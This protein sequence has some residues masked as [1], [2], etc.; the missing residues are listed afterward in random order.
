MKIWS[1]DSDWEYVLPPSRP[2]KFQLDIVEDRIKLLPCDAKV[3][4]LGSTPE[5]RD[6]AYQMEISNIY[7][8]DKSVDFYQKSSKM[9]VYNN[10]EILIKG[11]WLETLGN[12]KGCFDLIL[13][14]LTAGNIEYG[15]RS[16]F[17]QLIGLALKKD[18]IFIDKYLT[19]E[20]GVLTLDEI[21][22]KYSTIPINLATVNDFSC[23]AIFCSELQKAFGIIDTTMIYKQLSQRFCKNERLLK[24]IELA[25]YITPEECIWYYGKEIDYIDDLTLEVRKTLVG[26][27]Y[28]NRA[29]IYIWKK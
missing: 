13:S 2:N 4:I 9:R 19:N 23:E 8:F 12:Y 6:L 20:Q 18:G 17:Y 15:K 1:K 7:I 26:T 27:A 3:A 10:S 24:F 29:W 21:E 5:F 28:E 11:D 22:K 16:L 25:H 14:D